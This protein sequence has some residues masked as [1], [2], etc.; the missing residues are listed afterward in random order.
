MA[1]DVPA[2]RTRGGRPESGNS[3][4]GTDATISLSY[5]GKK[6]VDE[7]L[8]GAMAQTF[9]VWGVDDSPNE[10]VNRLY[11]G[12]NLPILRALLRDERVCGRVNLNS[13]VGLP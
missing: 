1:A 6:G 2:K 5:A 10:C 13:A 11:W 8:S 12:D 4:V 9:R 7:I 3:S